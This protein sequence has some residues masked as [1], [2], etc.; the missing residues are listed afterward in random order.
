MT[1]P[2]KLLRDFF[3]G[4]VY[5][6][7]TI[8]PEDLGSMGE[9]SFKSLCKSAGLIANKSDDDKGG[10]DYEI[11]HPRHKPINYSSH[12]YPVYR[13]QVKSTSSSSRQCRI[14]YSNLLNL[15]QYHGAA[16]VV[17]LVYNDGIE[18]CNAYMCHVDK[19]LSLDI[20]TDI[21]KK[22]LRS[23]DFKLNKRYKIMK[24]NDSHA[25]HPL[26]GSELV[27]AFDRNIG[28]DYLG[29]VERKAEYL[30]CF[31]KE[32]RKLEG[33][34]IFKEKSEL[35]SFAD[36][37]LGFNNE[38]KIDYEIYNAP[39]GLRDQQPKCSNEG[40][41]TTIHP[42]RNNIPNI[43]V[44]LKNSQH[45][46]EYKF[47]GKMYSLPS[48]IPSDLWATRIETSLFD[49]VLRYQDSGFSGF[50]LKNIFNSDIR[51]SFR[52]LYNV[53]S[54]LKCS[55]KSE[56]TFIR[57]ESDSAEKPAEI[58][59]G[60][61]IT[62]IPADFSFIH[63]VIEATYLRIREHNLDER[64]VSTKDIISNINHYHCISLANK[65]FKPEYRF[66]FEDRNTKLASADAVI[67]NATIRFIDKSF[68]ALVAFFGTINRGK[69]NQ[70]EGKF[71][72]SQLLGEYI[73]SP[74]SNDKDPVL[75]SEE[76]KFRIEL[77]GQGYAV[78]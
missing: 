73:V 48:S 56:K 17:L 24:F 68:V 16:F 32:G 77:A 49:I 37:L 15:I 50:Q 20:L 4:K 18:P 10:W 22:Q 35:A 69:E 45:G 72:R 12:A 14:T 26:A 40:I 60:K 67:F 64:E 30:R 8:R 5:K 71:N 63:E 25:I 11:E 51:V 38:F 70:F 9:C 62:E 29:Y 44:T 61:P 39:L 19:Q 6:M 65:S 7:A 55:Y 53:L 52:E 23:T 74:D 58:C 28:D 57:L 27:K 75:I 66:D 13:I 36:C 42:N 46:K 1:V 54:Y 33:T 34:F 31:E 3:F 78:L 43:S 59:L 41:V 47:S 21:R 76:N 2:N